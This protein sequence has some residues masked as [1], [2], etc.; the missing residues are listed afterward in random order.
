MNLGAR[1]AGFFAAHAVWC[2][3]DG[4]PLIPMLI[5]ELPSGERLSNRLAGDVGPTLGQEWLV[6]NHYHASRAVL[7]LDGFTTLESGRTDALLLDMKD[8]EEDRF[9]FSMTIPYRATE[10]PDGFAVFRP[11]FVAF[12]GAVSDDDYQEA[13]KSFFEGVDEH[14]EGSRVWNSHIDQSR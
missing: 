4:G 10:H 5:A 8:Y 3:S 6:S 14:S 2:L 7:I 9:S 13:V 1:M 12:A 11:K